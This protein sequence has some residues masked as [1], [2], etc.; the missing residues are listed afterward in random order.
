MSRA[1]GENS[2]L[3]ETL[4]FKEYV[5]RYCGWENGLGSIYFSKFVR[6][7]DVYGTAPLR[8]NPKKNKQFTLL[9]CRR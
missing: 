2:M 7:F 8:Q 3:A 4:Y 1:V 6:I 5:P 9:V